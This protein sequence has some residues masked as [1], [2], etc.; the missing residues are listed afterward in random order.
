MLAFSGA[1]PCI[2]EAALQSSG[3]ALQLRCLA[4]PVRSLALQVRSLALLLQWCV[5]QRCRWVLCVALRGAVLSVASEE[6]CVAGA[7]LCVA[8][9]VV[10]TSALQVGALR[11]V[12][13]CGA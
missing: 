2:A 5:A 1:T 8:V 12:A 9:A 4:L 13:W 7:E 10:R 6:H 3:V 11:C